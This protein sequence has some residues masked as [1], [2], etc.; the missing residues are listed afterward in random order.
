MPLIAESP[1]AGLADWGDV[2]GLLGD[3]IMWIA[4]VHAAAAI[5]HHVVLKDGVLAAMLPAREAR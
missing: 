2:H 3:T 5:F 4:G 1:I